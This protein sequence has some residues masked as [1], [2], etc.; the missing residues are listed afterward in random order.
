MSNRELVIDLVSRL[1]EN[2]PLEDIVRQLIDL[3]GEKGVSE[4]DIQSPSWHK[5]VLEEREERIRSGQETFIDWEKAKREL[6]AHLA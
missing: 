3:A 5:Q 4:T 6:R 1:P 2:T